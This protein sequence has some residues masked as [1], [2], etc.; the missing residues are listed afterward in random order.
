MS[1]KH[2][3]SQQQHTKYVPASQVAYFF[4]LD[5]SLCEW[6]GVIF[7][8]HFVFGVRSGSTGLYSFACGSLIYGE[9]L[10][11]LDNTHTLLMQP[12]R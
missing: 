7:H 1:S 11:L 3:C 12:Q 4:R 9:F 6:A 8:V 10:M 5:V 2:W